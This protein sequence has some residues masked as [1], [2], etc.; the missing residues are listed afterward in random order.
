[1]MGLV[2]SIAVLVTGTIVQT[3][4][5]KG[6]PNKDEPKTSVKLSCNDRKDVLNCKATSR[7]KLK[8]KVDFPNSESDDINYTG[9]CLKNQP[10]SDPTIEPNTTYFIELYECGTDST[11]YYEI[12][13][14]SNSKIESIMLTGILLP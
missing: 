4:E 7:Q 11:Y 2:L 10:F 5:A 12:K 8:H 1:M 14:D 6:P 13:I 3:V 9:P